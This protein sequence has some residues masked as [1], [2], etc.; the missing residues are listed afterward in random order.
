VIGGEFD[1]C[2]VSQ[3]GS[4]RARAVVVLAAAGVHRFGRLH[5][6]FLLPA[7]VAGHVLRLRVVCER[8]HQSGALPDCYI[9]K[10]RRITLV[11]FLIL[12]LNS[13]LS[14]RVCSV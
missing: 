11:F 3:G 8:S 10:G 1:A 5:V 14:V 2:A 9:Q 13:V 12:V 7:G 4:A 6:A